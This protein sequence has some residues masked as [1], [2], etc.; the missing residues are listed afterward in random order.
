MLT[1]YG[2]DNIIVMLAVGAILVFIGWYIPKSLYTYILIIPGIILI[3]FTFIF[4]RDPERNLPKGTVENPGYIIS[5]ADGKVLEVIDVHEERFMKADCR[6]ISIFLSPLDVHVNRIPFSGVVKFFYYHKGDYLVA[7]HPKSSEK[8]EQTYIGVESEFG[9]ILFKQ[10][11][12]VLARRLVW[13]I[14]EGDTVRVGERF[15]M[16]KFGSRM[17]IF[18]LPGTEIFV[19]PGDRV[20]AGETIVGKMLGAK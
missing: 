5:P 8:N 10:I 9:K 1:K 19:K 18:V 16:M 7:Y 17:D 6:R 4:F 14:K 12:G 2:T 13:D 11:V 20:V 3:I 15:G